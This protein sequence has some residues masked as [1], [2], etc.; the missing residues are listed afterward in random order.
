MYNDIPPD[1]L[2]RARATVDALEKAIRPLAAKL[3]FT[4]E[5]AITLNEAAVIG[6]GSRPN[7]H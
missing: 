2:E 4:L 6:E 5:P 7:G 1:A 3:P